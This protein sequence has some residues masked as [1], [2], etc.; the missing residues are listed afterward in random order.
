MTRLYNIQQQYQAITTAIN[1]DQK[2][3]IGK[4]GR[5]QY[6][7]KWFP[8]PNHWYK[9]NT[10]GAFSATTGR[11]ACGGVIQDTCGSFITGFGSH[12]P[13]ASALEVELWGLLRGARLAKRKG[14]QN[15]ILETDSALAIKLVNERVSATYLCS[16]LIEQIKEAASYFKVVMWSHILREA[17]SLADCLAKAVLDEGFGY[18]EFRSPPSFT[19]VP[20]LHD[21]VGSVADSVS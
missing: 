1:T 4:Q 5:I 6:L 9:V 15:V 14:L 20:L 17:N 7:L 16:S 8:P 11:A 13:C 10:D 12:L 19:L 3:F 18:R 21:G 2:A